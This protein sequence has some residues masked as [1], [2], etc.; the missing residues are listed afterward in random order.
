LK[1]QEYIESGIL[2]IYVLG[3]ASDEEQKEVEEMARQYP[4]IADELYSLQASMNEYASQ[5]EMAPPKSLKDK[6]MQ[7]II[8]ETPNATIGTSK[9]G[10]IFQYGMVA[11][12][13]LFLVS[14]FGN[15]YFYNQWKQTQND[16]AIVRNQ[17]IEIADNQKVLETKY[18]E[19]EGELSMVQN[20]AYHITY[21]EGMKD[22]APQSYAAVFWNDEKQQAYIFTNSLPKPPS[23]KQYQLWALTDDNIVWDAGVF[24]WGKFTPVKCFK[25]PQ[26]FI[27]TLEKEGGVPKAEGQAY[28]VGVVKI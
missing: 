6:I 16:L 22:M 11:S 21:L 5:F 10:K 19:L 26:K 25:K 28:A 8:D 4:E 2:S 18:R 17:N 24:H 13:A 23:G 14:L 1:I 9:N 27:I 7:N 15:L 20:P 3:I 12:V